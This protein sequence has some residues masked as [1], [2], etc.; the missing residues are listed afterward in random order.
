MSSL[1]HVSVWPVVAF[2][3]LITTVVKIGRTV[4]VVF[5][6]LAWFTGFIDT[7]VL[8]VFTSMGAIMQTIQ[9]GGLK[10]SGGVDFSALDYIGYVNAILPLSEFLGL[11]S[12]YVTAWMG[13]IV[14]RW[15]K[16]F[17]PTIA[18]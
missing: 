11:M 4:A 14:I 13:V 1:Q 12:I 9:P 2:Q 16:S 15:S 18:N 5:A 10:P 6:L 3:F 8:S 17:V 7:V